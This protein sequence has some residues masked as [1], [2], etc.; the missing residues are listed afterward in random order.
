MIN[1]E[2]IPNS[3]KKT[4]ETSRFATLPSQLQLQIKKYLEL[5]DFRTAKALFDAGLESKDKH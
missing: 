1:R 2:S 4:E 3:I 5:G